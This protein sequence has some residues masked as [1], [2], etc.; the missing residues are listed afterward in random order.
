VQL[1]RIEKKKKL[2]SGVLN[3][4]EEISDIV[5]IFFTGIQLRKSKDI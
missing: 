4:Q 3:E 2:Q 1:S 5:R